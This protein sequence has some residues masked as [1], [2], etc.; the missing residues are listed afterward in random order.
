MEDSREDLRAL[1]RAKDD[2]TAQKKA[3]GAVKSDEVKNL[4]AAL[5]PD[6]MLYKGDW[7]PASGWTGRCVPC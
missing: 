1:A 7:Y 6:A 2:P 5:K 3:V 4:R